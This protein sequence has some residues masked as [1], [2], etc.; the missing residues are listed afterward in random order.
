MKSVFISSTF[1]DMD[2]ER[3]ILNRRV[4][5]KINRQLAAY[6]QSVRI[7][8][9]RWGV[10]TTDMTEQDASEQVLAS[11]F[12]AIDNCKPYIIVLLGDRYGYIPNG[13]DI[14][15]TH[16]EIL[17]GVFESAGS[18]HIY[19]YM[20]D[21][22]YTGAPEEAKGTYIEQNE[23]SKA[24]L[25]SLKNE[26]SR[27]Y[28]DRC[29]H[30]SAKWSCEGECLVSDEFEGL[31]I[32][33]LEGDM[34]HES[35]EMRYRSDLHKQMCENDEILAERILCAY[36]NTAKI[37]TDIDEI[38][39]S[40]APTGIIGDGGAGKS[41]Y[42][43]LL[44]AAMRERGNRAHILFCGDNAFSASVRNAAETVLLILSDEGKYNYEE[45]SLL[46]Y[47]EL[48]E[49]ILDCRKADAEKQYLFLDA[50]DKCDKGMVNFVYWCN[51]FLSES[52]NIVFSSRMTHELAEHK[53]TF[54]MKE[55]S[56]DIDDYR[57]M[58]RVILEQSGKSISESHVEML[59]EKVHTPL[60][61]KLLLLRLLGLNSVDFDAIRQIGDGMDAINEYLRQLIS[62]SP[63][64]VEE[65]I[66]NYMESL[67]E[68]SRDQNW[69]VLILN[70]LA[71]SEYGLSEDDMRKM[72][73]MLD[74]DWV[75]LDYL[76]FL[77]RFAFFIRIRDNGRLDISHD[78]VRR[79]V[80]AYFD[81]GSRMMCDLIAKY[82]L[83][84][85][86]T[87]LATVR[88]LFAVAHRGERYRHFLAFILKHR[89][90]FSSLDGVQGVFAAEMRTG[91]QS[92]F[93]KDGGEFLFRTVNICENIEEVVYFQSVIASSLLHINDF[94]D[95][96]T[97]INIASAVMVIP[98]QVDVFDDALFDAE[99]RSCVAFMRRHGVSEE[100]VSAFA[101]YN[102][103]EAAKCRGK[104]ERAEDVSEDDPISPLMSA[105]ESD[106][107]K[108]VALAWIQLS[109]MAKAMAK[110]PKTAHGAEELGLKLLDVLG[111]NGIAGYEAM[112]EIMRADLYT[113]L[114]VACKSLKEWEK[115][116]SYDECS[117]EIYKAIYESNPTAE[118]F[119]KYRSRVYNVANV[120]E[121]WAMTERCNRELWE[122][123][124]EAF[125][126]S[127]AL[128]VKAISQGISERDVM[129]SVSSIMA[130]GTA[131][132][133]TERYSEGI[134][135]YNEGIDLAVNMA[136]NNAAPDLYTDLCVYLLEC[137]YQ[138]LSNG[139][140]DAAKGLGVRVTEYL[141]SVIKTGHE[142]HVDKIVKICIAFSNQLNDIIQHQ[143]D[144]GDIDGQQM[145]SRILYDIYMAILP[146]APHGIRANIISTMANICAVLFWQ[147]RDYAAAYDEYL[148][149]L[150]T[151]VEYDLAAPDEDGRFLDQ[152]NTRLVDA[153]VRCI[154]CLEKLERKEGMSELLD[155]AEKWATYFADHTEVAKGDAPRVLFEI[156]ASLN[157]NGSPLSM[158]F[159]SL[160]MEGIK[161]EKY[162]AEEH[163][164]TVKMIVD[165]FMQMMGAFGKDAQNDN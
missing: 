154:L 103:K 144:A 115:A 133:N 27:K 12:K 78:V 138:L 151:A 153:Y 43:S 112:T 8:D 5:P 114:G 96:K 68:D 21:A 57:A 146:V 69:A 59:I 140:S 95:E 9:L 17:R 142:M 63:D 145:T 58:V 149:L 38:L 48:I 101:E 22:D 71:F 161:A 77:E 100:T 165:A 155:N 152:A 47:D 83:E 104:S 55:M 66:A 46:S 82:M 148:D 26:L 84:C 64:N 128:E 10:D 65:M 79:T 15:V 44:C 105:L 164:E 24:M 39:S 97:I 80:C 49:K 51:S 111:D 94:Y 6:N 70:L 130:L 19:I 89:E 135:K 156:F 163:K 125:E 73:E 98:T 160:A 3:D 54:V 136:K 41:V 162:I 87:D 86:K 131:L 37:F 132:I 102:K 120:I 150:N 1:R 124:R 147:K 33:D 2:F 81:E 16:M 75:S 139:Q 88:T 91:I 127:Y 159:L 45:C 13:S 92:L 31:V 52:L 121:A 85:G 157:R 109:D 76:D 30:Y 50:I 36:S 40:K 123:T 143:H 93:L 158:I 106:N 61:L 20:R 67:I 28:P 118:M 99:L 7:L 11:C 90:A 23:T 60:E 134:E 117:L 62:D 56:Y 74:T 35:A 129:H 107:T 116:I 122:R 126:R 119:R 18:D 108:D 72:L 14:S 4:A 32:A 53:D 25:E 137:V 29:R 34:V 110:S 42:M 113:T 141:S